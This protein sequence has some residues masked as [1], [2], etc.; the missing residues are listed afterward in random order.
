[1]PVVEANGIRIHYL[2]QGDGPPVV[3]LPGGN[4]HAAM[5][6]RAH[7]RLLERYRFIAVDPRG[8]GGTTAFVAAASYAPS[9]LAAD[10]LGFLDALGLERP[11]L[12]GHSR[13]ARAVLEFARRFPQR[14]QAVVAVAPP[15]L[16]AHGERREFYLRAAQ[17][18]RQEGIDP[19]LKRLPSAPRHP[20]RRAE[21]E[22]HLRA[23][24]AEALAA[25]YE[26]L[27]DLRPLTEDPG[28]LTM[29]ILVVCGQHDRMLDDARALAATVPSARL[30]VIPRAGHAPFS[31]A[32][33]E[34]FAVVEAFLAEVTGSAV[35]AERAG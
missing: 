34:Y 22:A 25:Q 28:G 32:K 24:G 11:V 27:A 23:V 18:L 4:D 16:G 15:A 5:A 3:W 7:E 17:K 19:F 20:E 33:P 35:P 6:L 29:P 30:V 31:E 1:M 2:E 8:Q 14:V 9:L 26:A 13:G 10:L 21:W 12:G